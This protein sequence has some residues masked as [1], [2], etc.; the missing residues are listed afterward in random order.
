[1]SQ[2][3]SSLNEQQVVCPHCWHEFYTDHALYIATHPT[4]Y[5][6]SVLGDSEN[7]RLTRTEVTFDRNRMPF[8]PKGGRITE[9]ACPVC[10]LQIPPELLRH[11]A[12]FISLVGA[13]SAGKTYFLTS[14]LHTLRSELSKNFAY[15]LRDGD[16]HQIRAFLSHENTLFAPAD[17]DK[18]TRLKK[19]EEAGSLYSQVTIDGQQYQLPIP[20]VF[21]LAP[22]NSHP[23]LASGRDL[24]MPVVLYDN[25][26]E[27][28]DFLKEKVT[29]SRVTQHLG[30]CDAVLFAF[31]PVLDPQTRVRLRSASNDPQVETVARN[32]RQESIL[33]EVV[34]RIRRQ[35]QLPTSTRISTPLLVCVQK[36]D[37]WKSLVPYSTTTAEDGEVVENIDH[38][39][40]VFFEKHGIAGLD[41]EELSRISLLVRA[42]LQDIDPAFVELAE[43]Q[44]EVVR[45]FP[46]SALGTSPEFEEKRNQSSHVQDLLGVRPSRI[47]PFRVTHPFLW[48]MLRWKVIRPVKKKTSSKG[49]PTCTVQVSS[50]QLRV[51]L[52]TSRRILI[53]DREYGGCE[54]IDPF[55][56]DSVW[57]PH[58]QVAAA[59]TKPDVPPTPSLDALKLK[60]PEAPAAPPKRGW[61]KK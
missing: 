34:N 50:G 22:T 47:H 36:Y 59:E 57:I 32:Y 55:N 44:F 31:D 2:F 23:D 48:L 1:M 56:G 26:G 37:I 9:K 11:K 24:N 42:F 20:F 61:F 30:K 40:V 33:T 3:D 54:I 13:P 60:K 19:T 12:K 52:P 15:A 7:Q 5:G 49:L 14:M 28:F 43:S 6:D 45:Y 8:D 39:S 53:L 4:L 25:A 29:T 18:P 38:S 46:V 27:S 41:N 35:R 10:H 51:T 16:S 17:P 21:S 58:T